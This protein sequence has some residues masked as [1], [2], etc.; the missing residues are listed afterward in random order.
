MVDSIATDVSAIAVFTPPQST[1]NGSI[2]AIDLTP[3]MLRFAAGAKI[4]WV[5]G[6]GNR[7]LR[8]MLEQYKVD[9]VFCHYMNCA[10]SFQRVWDTQDIPLYIHC[11]GYDITWDMPITAFPLL[12][13]FS[14]QYIHKAIKLAN[15][16][17]LIVNSKMTRHRLIKE[18]F[19]E[20]RITVKY[21]GVPVASEPP[22]FT[23]TPEQLEILF[24]GRLV[25]C[26]GPDLTIR[27]FEIAS[28]NGLN[29][30][31]TIAGDGTLYSECVKLRDRSEFRDRIRLLGSV[32][33]K[34]GVLLR[35]QSHIF[36]AHNCVGPKT[37]QVESYGVSVVEAMAAGIPVVTGRSGGVCETVVDGETGL[38]FEP[39]DIESHADAL[40]RLNSDPGLRQRLG[41]AG[42]KRARD[43]F[44]I[45]QET[46]QLRK[47]LGLERA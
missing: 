23:K 9:A 39:M 41:H 31:L 46:V 35:R 4:K 43:Q 20:K 16:S 12:R 28:R 13:R 21:I 40:L 7:I 30:R 33:A 29:G 6:L 3:R 36:T 42:W 15:R 17:H 11:H 37:K 47:I 14:R 19:P 32:D 45:E 34:T 25:D 38:L 18:G 2:P 26:K 1:W 5:P 22:E 24:L 10:A 44:S 27:A 8:Q